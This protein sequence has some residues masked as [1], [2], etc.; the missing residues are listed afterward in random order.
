MN[1]GDEKGEIL[2]RGDPARPRAGCSSWERTAATA[3]SAP[4]QVVPPEARLCSI[5][6]SPA[7]AGSPAASGTMRGWETG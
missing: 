2:D 6:F 4:A 3:R 1:V 7:N 5:E